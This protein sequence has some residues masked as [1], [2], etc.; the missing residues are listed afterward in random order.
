VLCNQRSQ[1]RR[2]VS[3]ADRIYSWMHTERKHVYTV[4]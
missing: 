4:R 3:C 2:S 1:E